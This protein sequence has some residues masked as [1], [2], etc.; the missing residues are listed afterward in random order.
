M[1]LHH[2]GYL[3]AD[4]VAAREEFIRLGFS[5]DGE[6]I[7][8]AARGAH[9][10]FLRTGG[11]L[12]ELICPDSPD[13]PLAPLLKKIKNMPYHLCFEVNDLET[14][15]ED[16]FARG[17]VPVKPPEAA[18]ALENRRVAFYL[19]GDIGMIELVEGVG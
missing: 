10:C 9:I 19:H 12:I 7:Y 13:S 6:K 5:P 15:Q 4:I 11:T 3:V 16:F 2:V 8:D 17:Y 14:A 18:P 1:T